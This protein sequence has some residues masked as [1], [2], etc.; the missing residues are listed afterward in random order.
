[1]RSL[2][3]LFRPRLWKYLLHRFH[4]CWNGLIDDY[5]RSATSS[6]WLRYRGNVFVSDYNYLLNDTSSSILSGVRIKTPIGP[7]EKVTGLY[8][9]QSTSLGYRT[10]ID[11]SPGD[12]IRI[13]DYTTI[14]PDCYILGD[15]R[16]GRYCLVAPGVFISSRNHHFMLHPTWLIR[17]QDKVVSTDS[18]LRLSENKPVIIEDDCWIGRCVLIKNGTYIGKGAVIGANSVVTSDVAPYSIHAGVPNRKIGQRTAF[19]PPDRIEAVDESHWP[20]FYSGFDMWRSEWETSLKSGVLH[21]QG[22]FHVILRGGRFGQLHLQG[23]MA[24]SLSDL[25]YE[26]SCNGITLGSLPIE[27]ARF[28]K[29][30][31]IEDGV[32]AKMALCE[33]PSVL[34]GYNVLAFKP[35][36]ATANPHRTSGDKGKQVGIES[37]SIS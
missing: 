18:S 7:C 28:R 31:P 21:A 14:N 10:T 22:E 25:E 29:V 34:R 17:D 37:V 5:E 15:V 8:L 30:L 6:N 20:Y 35:C 26:V 4:N 3:F 12:V 32:W 2:S 11:L 19:S 24:G 13:G 16:I 23:I 27:L 1:M 33:P 36:R 9:G